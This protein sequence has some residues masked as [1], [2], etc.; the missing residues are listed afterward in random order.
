[1]VHLNRRIKIGE[2]VHELYISHGFNRSKFLKLSESLRSL[3]SVSADK[4]PQKELFETLSKGFGTVP[5][6]FVSKANKNCGRV[7]HL[8][9]RVSEKFSLKTSDPQNYKSHF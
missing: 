3:G 9:E 1:M 2:G 4:R 7:A 6:R 5:M 8:I